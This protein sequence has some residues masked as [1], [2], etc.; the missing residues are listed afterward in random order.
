MIINLTRSNW[1]MYKKFHIFRIN[2]IILELLYNFVLSFLAF[3]C[4]YR[5]NRLIAYSI[6]Q[7]FLC[8]YPIYAF[9]RFMRLPFDHVVNCQFVLPD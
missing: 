3:V 4:L 6:C 5:R 9:N 2:C 8:D 1:N 7:T